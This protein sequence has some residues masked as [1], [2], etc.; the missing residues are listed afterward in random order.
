MRF[1]HV[2]CYISKRNFF[3]FNIFNS[4]VMLVISNAGY[5]FVNLSFLFDIFWGYPWTTVA[6]RSGHQTSEGESVSIILKQECF[7]ILLQK[8]CIIQKPSCRFEI[9]QLIYFWEF[10]KVISLNC[11]LLGQTFFILSFSDSPALFFQFWNKI[12]FP[13]F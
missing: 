6:V 8:T 5:W 10:Y 11:V 12:K 2:L 3:A 1:A 13:F 9:F 7:W 4:S